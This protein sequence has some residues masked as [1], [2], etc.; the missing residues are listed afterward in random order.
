M[1]DNFSTDRGGG[2]FGGDSNAIHL[3]YTLF[4][5]VFCLH[6][7]VQAQVASTPGEGTMTTSVLGKKLDIDKEGW[8]G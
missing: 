6:A 8:P 1:E 4:L 7:V 3:L 5:F 2:W